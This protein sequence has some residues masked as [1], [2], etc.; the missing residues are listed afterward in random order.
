MGTTFVTI[1]QSSGFWMQDSVL[2]LW[3]RLLALNVEESPDDESIGR[4]IRDQW[5]LASKGFFGGHVP[6]GLESFASTEDGRWVIRVAI[7]SLMSRLRDAPRELNGPTL[8]L[9][10][11]DGASFVDPI[12]TR[13]LV[14]VGNAF[15]Q[16]M[17]GKITSDASSTEFMPGSSRH[18][19]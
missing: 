19:A 7:E 17:D 2:E 15:L 14:E 12:E 8:D 6:H 13:R 5:L 4:R 10:G 18:E 9:L 11:V 1:D 3:L 16:L